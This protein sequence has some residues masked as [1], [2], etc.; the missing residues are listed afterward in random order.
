[1]QRRFCSASGN[2]SDRRSKSRQCLLVAEWSG[3]DNS[4]Q[5]VKSSCPV[6]I[7]YWTEI[8]QV[9]MAP[10]SVIEP[11][12]VI[13]DIRLCLLPGCV[14]SSSDTLSF[15]QRKEALHDSIVVAAAFVTHAAGDAVGFEQFLE[16]IT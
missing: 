1:M 2:I 12:Y 15:E 7:L 14:S 3:P 10:F 9:S 8:A 16:I 11:F 13:E 6:F 5:L 4:D